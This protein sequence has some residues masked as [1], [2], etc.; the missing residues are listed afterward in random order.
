M[1]TLTTSAMRAYQEHTHGRNKIR[2]YDKKGNKKGK[3]LQA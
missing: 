3:P 2:P 1:N